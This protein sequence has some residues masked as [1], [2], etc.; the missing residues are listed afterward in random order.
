MY[1]ASQVEY[2]PTKELM[3]HPLHPYTQDMLAAMPE[4]GLHFCGGFAMSHEDY[5]DAGCKYAP[6]CRDCSE[7][8]AGSCP[9]CLR[10]RLPQGKVLKYC[11]ESL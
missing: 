6:R 1:A 10:R 2:A 11:N 5:E 9:R 3:E 7:K 4:N 8:N